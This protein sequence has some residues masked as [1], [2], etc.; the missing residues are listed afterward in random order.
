MFFLKNINPLRQLAN[1]SPGELHSLQF[2]SADVRAAA[3]Q[4]LAANAGDVVLPPGLEP[5]AVLAVPTLKDEVRAAWP[6]ELTLVPGDVVIPVNMATKAKTI[7]AGK[8]KVTVAIESAQYDLGFVSTIHKAQGLTMPRVI[9]SLLN[10]PGT[11]S[12]EDFHALYVLLTRVKRGGDFRVLA[13]LT[14]LDFVEDLLPPVELLAFEE[15]YGED[16]TWHRDRAMAALDRHR[17]NRREAALERKA[18]RRGGHASRG[19]GGRAAASGRRGRARGRSA[20]GSGAAAADHAA[21]G[22][23]RGRG[24]GRARGRS[25]AGSG[26]AA[27]DHAAV[28]STAPAHPALAL[29]NAS[30][31]GSLFPCTPTQALATVESDPVRFAGLRHGDPVEPSPEALQAALPS[32]SLSTPFLRYIARPRDSYSFVYVPLLRAACGLHHPAIT[33]HRNSFFG[34]AVWDDLVTRLRLILAAFAITALPWT[35]LHGKPYM[36]AQHQIHLLQ[37]DERLR[38]ERGAPVGFNSVHVRVE[39]AIAWQLAAAGRVLASLPVAPGPPAAR[40]L[41]HANG[42][43][44]LAPSRDQR[45]AALAQLNDEQLAAG[46]RQ[47]L[48]G[49]EEVSV[50]ARSHQQCLDSFLIA[51]GLY[52]LDSLVRSKGQCAFDSLALL[53]GPPRTLEQWRGVRVSESS[54]LRRQIVDFLTVSGQRQVEGQPY[55]FDQVPRPPR[56]NVPGAPEQG[57]LEFVNS[58]HRKRAFIDGPG[59]FA[60]AIVMQRPIRVFST[61]SRLEV[62]QLLYQP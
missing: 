31:R 53:N 21:A 38:L 57:Y 39:T 37:L 58:L 43:A 13:D 24:R 62:E 42:V 3:L 1:G 20:A 4:F 14:D 5:S 56:G 29:S 7:A 44:G 26:A 27:A 10:R 2:P 48:E 30:L 16:G 9:M 46:I 17:T 11:P 28:G 12:R 40:E 50:I 34:P 36:A 60:A 15:G 54:N 6:A 25:A 35:T 41:G 61:T 49:D 32:M 51:R 8:R 52:S 33:A 45:D 22:S 55:T 47:S 23:L 18:Q 19:R 59:L